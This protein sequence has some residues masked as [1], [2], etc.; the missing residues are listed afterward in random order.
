M[1][2]LFPLQEGRELGRLRGRYSANLID[3][4]ALAPSGGDEEPVADSGSY[5]GPAVG[6]G[7]LKIFFLLAFLSLAAVIGRSFD[8]QIAR[9]D[10]Y[11]QQAEKNRSRIA[12]VPSERGVI[13]DRNGQTLVNNVASLN[14]T[15]TP[16]DLPKDP[17]ERRSLIGRIADILGVA[18]ADIEAKMAE[19]QKYPTLPVA[20]SDE[21][22]HEQAVLISIE[23]ARTGGIAL[24]I[25]TRRDYALSSATPSLS[26][27]LG[28][29]GRV[30]Q[31][32]L[33]DGA[34]AHD[35]AD[36]IG[37]TGLE[38]YYETLLRGRYAK[39]TVE[40]D[41]RGKEKRVITE[42][43]GAPGQSLVLSI[44]AD[45]QKKAEE[46]FKNRLR[47]A[48]KT[49]GSLIV[50]SPKTGEILA[51]VS[52]PA[53]DNNLFAKGIST[54][55]YRKLSENKDNPMFSRAVSASL[56][57][58]S[59]F[60]LAI[61]AA[62]IDDG[63]ITPKTTVMSVGGIHVGKWFF[64]DWKA[65]GHGAT[66]LSK[67]LAESVNTFFYIVG[68]GYE[69]RPGLGADR[70]VAFAKKFG[71][72]SQ[73]GIDLPGEG[74][75]FLPSKEWKERVK[76]ESWYIGDTY[77][78]AIGQGDV[79]VTP[80]QIA[81]MTSVIASGGKLMRPHLVNATISADGTRTV[82][83]PEVMNAHV[84]TPAAIQAVRQGLRQAVTQ[85]SARSLGDLPVAVAAKTGTA[86]WSSTSP[87][88]AW[89]TSFA[90]YND[91]EIVVTVVI[92]DGGEGSAAAAPV[93]KD[94][95]AWYFGSRPRS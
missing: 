37:K 49:R 3:E 44:D 56:P 34:G 9:G 66:D 41:A 31:A 23:S 17:A 5:I 90:P 92:E 8:M 22:T 85:G 86:Q 89:F 61:G 57:A 29:E 25:G 15:V 16:A 67:A 14:V 12:W 73:L 21:I 80:L 60:K 50:M 88:H 82:R 1:Q 38:K 10:F 30:T 42:D 79:L 51:M 55:D 43:A 45:L 74:D 72:G 71:F 24:R 36:I 58:G 77:H 63:V 46:I 40:V 2:D 69:D 95:Y 20:I 70:I 39:R 62:A 52:E 68:G 54:A 53:F 78:M 87:P 75:G 27:I 94:L 26:H 4:V 28:Y 91:P 83:E 6:G 48:G 18:P 13:Y 84:A 47:L 7:R 65:G 76:K 64:P 59:T 32:D 33:Q 11:R 81:S 93:A 19:F 35:P